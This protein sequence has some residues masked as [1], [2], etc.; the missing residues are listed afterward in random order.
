MGLGIYFS[1][2]QIAHQSDVKVQVPT[3]AADFPM[4]LYH[5]P[6]TWI[7]QQYNLKQYS[8]FDRGGHFA[9]MEE[10]DL[11]MDDMNKFFQTIKI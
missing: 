2:L 8:A 7:E 6:R 9:A 4:D 1:T 5:S 10:P 3:A 11:L